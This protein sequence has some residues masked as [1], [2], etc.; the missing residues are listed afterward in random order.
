MWRLLFSCHHMGFY[1]KI[2]SRPEDVTVQV[3]YLLIMY[4]ALGLIPAQLW[5]W[6]TA[7]EMKLGFRMCSFLSYESADNKTSLKK[8]RKNEASNA[9]SHSTAYVCVHD[10]PLTCTYTPTQNKNL[11]YC[12]LHMTDTSLKFQLSCLWQ[13]TWAILRIGD[14]MKKTKSFNRLCIRKKNKIC[15]YVKFVDIYW[16]E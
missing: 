16:L 4:G 15:L 13:N 8:N 10:T 12:T 14:L 5:M 11:S 6:S 3:K 2:K 7:H 9:K 1:F